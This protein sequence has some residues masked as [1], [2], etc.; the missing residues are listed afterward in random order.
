[1]TLYNKIMLKVWLIVAIAVFAITTYMCLVDDYRQ[2]IFYYLVSVIALL[3]YFVK[4]W[5]I[6]RMNAHLA[7]LEEEKRKQAL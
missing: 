5:M 3:M 6:K 4:K 1:M 2:W 7:F